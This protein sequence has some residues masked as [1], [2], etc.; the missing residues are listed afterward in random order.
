MGERVL[1]FELPVLH[2]PCRVGTCTY[3]SIR[4]V[5]VCAYMYGTAPSTTA[6]DGGSR[7]LVSIVHVQRTCAA[8]SSL[9]LVVLFD[10]FMFDVLIATRNSREFQYRGRMEP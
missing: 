3:E 5:P 9:P 4:T 2:V 8:F 10:H 1:L 6:R 7:T